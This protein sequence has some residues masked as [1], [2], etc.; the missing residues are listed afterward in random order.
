MGGYCRNH[1]WRSEALFSKIHLDITDHPWQ[2]R[3]SIWD[4]GSG[5]LS[6]ATQLW[7]PHVEIYICRKTPSKVFVFL[8]KKKFSEEDPPDLKKK[9]PIFEIR[10]LL[11]VLIVVCSFAKC[12][13]FVFF[14]KN[15]HL[16]SFILLQV[17]R[18]NWSKKSRKFGNILPHS[19]NSW[20][21][22]FVFS[23]E[24]VL[25]CIHK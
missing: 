2:I 12:N 5:D 16:V 19:S 11:A 3:L 15:Y 22:T 6:L 18:K 9:D 10:R 13:K 4:A 14:H 21:R 20:I 24:K 8:H 25:N 17:G 7:L 23:K 1:Y